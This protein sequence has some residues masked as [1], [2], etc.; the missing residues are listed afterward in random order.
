M[1]SQLMRRE[2]VSSDHIPETFH[3]ELSLYRVSFIKFKGRSY[4]PQ[5]L[6]ITAL[7]SLTPVRYRQWAIRGEA[8]SMLKG[9]IVCICVA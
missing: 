8:W 2:D 4:S 5:P 3:L 6:S 9:R 7:E 1:T